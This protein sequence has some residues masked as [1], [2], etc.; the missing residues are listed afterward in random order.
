MRDPIDRRQA[1]RR[2]GAPAL[3]PLLR[4]VHPSVPAQE[5]A[6]KPRF[7]HEPEVET[8][9]ALAER[10]IPETDTPGA[11]GALVHQY[12][13]FVLSEDE[14]AARERFR[15]GLAWLDRRSEALFGRPFARL[16]EKQQDELLTRLSQESPAVEDAEGAAFFVGAKRL[17]VDGYYRSEAGMVQELGFE[18]RTFLAEFEGC[19]HP[20]HHAWKVGE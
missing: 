6:W 7:F 5:G 15:A 12:I 2:L 17:T 9:S 4:H 8:V 14:P 10:I 20:E 11:R 18:G 19:T 3:V 16:D 1:L 13:D